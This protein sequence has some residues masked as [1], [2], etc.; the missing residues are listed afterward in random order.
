MVG[1]EKG[2]ELCCTQVADV[3]LKHL[4][5]SFGAIIAAD[6]LTLTIEKGEFVTLLGPS[7]SGK[8]TTLMM[9][10]GFE[11]PTQ[12]DILI[13]GESIILKPPSKRNIGIVFQHYSL[14]PH[15]TVFENI[16][17]PLRMRK[18]KEPEIVRKV[19]KALDL[20]QLLDYDSR[21]PRQLS[22]GQQQRIALAR[23][24]VFDPPIL[25]MDEPLG[26][27]DKNLREYMQLE[28]KHIQKQLKITT[29]Y[30][31]HDQQEAL[32]MSDRIAVMNH[33]RIEQVGRP[34]EVY[35]KPCNLFVSGFI[36]ESNFLK[37][38]ITER[39]EN[40]WVV[41][42]DS[43]LYVCVPYTH[44]LR[45]G[46]IVQLAIRP[47]RINFFKEDISEDLN[48]FDGVVAE[49]TYIGETIKYLIRL[50]G[51][52]LILVKK[53][54]SAEI[55]KHERGDTVRVGWHRESVNI[56]EAL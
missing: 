19:K 54:N 42:T 46:A 51:G 47:E 21:Y 34:E 22:G 12:G 10:A 33:G 28:I 56:L 4:S 36:G 25:L 53:P 48:I 5:K 23:A 32:T 14:F 3:Y 20:V 6:N 41:M 1:E 52:E 2:K 11:T 44:S 40:S 29:I 39:R 31:T 9:I 27:L 8:T 18:L 26:A 24:L 55:Q 50:T 30:V 15:M 37:G 49:L 17:F 7:G 16:A 38:K 45:T 43:N 13:G 35:E